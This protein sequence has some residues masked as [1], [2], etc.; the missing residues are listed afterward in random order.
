[1]RTFTH[2][3]TKEQFIER[4]SQKH[5]NFYDYSL[6]EYED[7]GYGFSYTG[8]KTRALP[9]YYG[10]AYVIILCPKHGAFSQRSRR[11]LEGRGCKNCA[12]ED[13]S[14]AL[15]GRDGTSS[16][17]NANQHKI[18][19]N[20]TTIFHIASDG[21]QREILIDNQDNLI[22]EYCSWRTTGHEASKISKQR[23]FYFVGQKTNR[24]KE[25]NY[26]WL[27]E[28]P[29][30]HRMVMS[31]VLGRELA[32]TEQVDHINGNGLDN[33]REN[34]RLATNAQ[35]HFNMPKA[36]TYNGVAPSSQYKGVHWSKRDKK[37]RAGIG[38]RNCSP[39]SRKDLGKFDIEEDAAR[40]YDKAAIELY[41]NFAYTNF[42]IEDYL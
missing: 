40:T 19:T 27:G 9:E 18:G 22:L 14:K 39:P 13:R 28:R 26:E 10:E 34:L 38:S 20:H 41:G 11:H 4:S 17:I 21:I 8:T 15:I 36:R 1:M 7:R 29:K 23:A 32:R 3:K 2:I 5:D 42:P 35:N 16:F 12:L 6:V 30:M 24:I 31:R 25:E 33:R 37:W